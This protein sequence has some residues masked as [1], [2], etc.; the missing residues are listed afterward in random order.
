MWKALARLL[1]RLGKWN[2]SEFKPSERKYII[3]LLPHTS[4]M[5]IVLS[6][7]YGVMMGMNIKG[8]IKK[9]GFFFPL[10]YFVRAIGGIP[11][12]RWK[13]AHLAEWLIAYANERE[14]FGLI[15][16]PEGTRRKIRRLK[17][18][19]YHIATETGMP[20]Y[21]G[22]IDYKTRRLGIGPKMPVTGDYHADLQI[23]KDFYRGME[24]RH[25]GLFDA[26]ILC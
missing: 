19:F 12:D 26:E 13:N 22:Y 15:L 1:L 18:G 9:E 20:V 23:L 2:F 14:D 16:S 24:G 11:V 25:P 4:T 3:I 5:D 17:R 21:M 7:V 6:K 10:G 8:L